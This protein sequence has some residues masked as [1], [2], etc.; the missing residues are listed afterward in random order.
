MNSTDMETLTALASFILKNKITI[1]SIVSTQNYDYE[2][3][4]YFDEVV[5]LDADDTTLLSVRKEDV[6]E[7]T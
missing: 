2:I 1:N 5:V 7:K 3:V 6:E 4:T